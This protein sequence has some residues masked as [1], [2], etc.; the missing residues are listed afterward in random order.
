MRSHQPKK[1]SLLKRSNQ[2]KSQLRKKRKPNKKK[3]LKNKKKKTS[4]KKR[5]QNPKKRSQSPKKKKNSLRSQKKM[6]DLK[7]NKNK[8]LLTKRV[9]LNF[10]V[11]QINLYF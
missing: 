9:T 3:R 4:L 1:S 11:S 6:S 2:K 10:V 7:L 8:D 5:K